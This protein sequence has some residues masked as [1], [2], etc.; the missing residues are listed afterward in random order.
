M[1][2]WDHGTGET[3]SLYKFP[4]AKHPLPVIPSIKAMKFCPFT[5]DKNLKAERC[6][7]FD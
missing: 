6:V 4:H 7:M 2:F 5:G 1:K 3:I